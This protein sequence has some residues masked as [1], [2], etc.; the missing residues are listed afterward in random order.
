MP[1]APRKAYFP[2]NHTRKEDPFFRIKFARRYRETPETRF[3]P[4]GI[5]TCRKFS[6]GSTRAGSGAVRR[7]VV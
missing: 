1:E 3:L 7:A 6:N 5:A 4:P 2:K